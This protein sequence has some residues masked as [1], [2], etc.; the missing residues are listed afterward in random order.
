MPTNWPKPKKPR[1]QPRL[2][3]SSNIMI[4]P[5]Y[6]YCAARMSAEFFSERQPDRLAS[7]YAG[8]IRPCFH[9][10]SSRRVVLRAHRRPVRPQGFAP[11]HCYPDR[12]CL[13]RYRLFAG[14]LG[15]RHHGAYPA[16]PLPHPARFFRRRGNRQRGFLRREWA[17]PSRQALYLSFVPSVANFGKA[18]AAGLAGLTAYL[19]AGSRP[20]GHGACL[21]SWPCL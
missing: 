15:N 4:F 6:G 13:Y 16:D 9:C 17:P 7:V 12:P 5:V 2:E 14:L 3:P 1:Q 11:R 18:A 21:S 10:P 19:F 20:R 8:R